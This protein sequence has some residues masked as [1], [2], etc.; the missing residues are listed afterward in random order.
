MQ[1]EAQ[2]VNG[3]NATGG[4]GL[5]MPDYSLSVVTHSVPPHH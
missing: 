5:F 4:W 1:N 2:G 3:I